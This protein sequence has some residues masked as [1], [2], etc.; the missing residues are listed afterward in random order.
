MNQAISKHLGMLAQTASVG[1]TSFWLTGPDDFDTC[2]LKDN[3][4]EEGVLID[5]GQD[6][7]LSQ[8]DKRSFRL[9][10]AYVPVS[11][12]EAGVKI[13]AQEVDKLL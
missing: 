2:L 7:Y 4:K 12:M 9:G 1:G 6:Y 3:L 8:N 10:F 5:R 13:I 11:K